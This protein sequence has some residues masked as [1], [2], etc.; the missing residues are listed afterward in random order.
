L[1]EESDEG[2]EKADETGLSNDEK[3]GMLR[4]SRGR[5]AKRPPPCPGGP[6]YNPLLMAPRKSSLVL[7]LLSFSTSNSMA[8]TSLS[9]LRT[10][11]RIKMRLRSVSSKSSSS[12]RVPDE[13]AYAHVRALGCHPEI[14]LFGHHSF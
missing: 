9:W 4:V 12:L 13:A 5:G 2:Q 3:M 11:R 6:S 14:V 8:S 1:P 10:M 7:V